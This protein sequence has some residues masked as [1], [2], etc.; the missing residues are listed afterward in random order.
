MGLGSK[1]DEKMT[2]I[3]RKTRKIVALAPKLIMFE[4][5][6]RT[7]PERKIERTF[8]NTTKRS[9]C[10]FFCMVACPFTLKIDKVMASSISIPEF[11][12]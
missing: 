1:I 10:P 11:H 8:Y 12:I 7:F 9:Q 6:F 4:A 2:E 3:S 5:N